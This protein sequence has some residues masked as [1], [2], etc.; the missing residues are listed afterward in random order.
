VPPATVAILGSC[1]SRD[2]FNTQFNP[3]YRADFECVLY[4]NHTSALT[5]MSPLVDESWDWLEPHIPNEDRP[6]YANESAVRDEFEKGFLDRLQEIQPDYL[7]LDFFGDIHW[8]VLEVDDG[9]FFTHHPV[10]W[11]S[12]NIYFKWAKEGRLKAWHPSTHLEFYFKAWSAAFVAFMQEV[13]ARVP[14]TRVLL[15]RGHNTNTVIDVSGQRLNFQETRPGN[16]N[17]PF[18]PIDVGFYNKIWAIF[19]DFAARF[20][21]AEIAL[22][23]REWVTSDAHP[24]GP[25]YVHFE[26]D[27][28]AQ[29]LADMNEYDT[30]V[31]SVQMAPTGGLSPEPLTIHGQLRHPQTAWFQSTAGP[32][33]ALK[34]SCRTADIREQA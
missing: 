12:T 16:L 19:D 4:Q 24:W 21:N 33:A 15:H 11:Q 31:R 34:G 14:N 1:I 7:L 23:G 10:L 9:R 17:H 8:G 30:Y 20:V 3:G 6:V 13:R 2:A 29:V 27:Y 25:F 32:R 22:T 18:H 26:P 5:L 28:Y